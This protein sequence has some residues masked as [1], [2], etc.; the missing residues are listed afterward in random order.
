MTDIVRYDLHD[1]IAVLRFDDGKANALSPTAIAALGEAARRAGAEA[2][3]TVLLGREGRFSAGFDLT[4]M[5]KGPAEARA[6]VT[7]GADLLLG[8]ALHPR[9]LVVACTGHALAA[10]AIFLLV[11]D[12]RIGANGPFKLGF[13]EVA[14]GL[15][16]P[17]FLVELARDR[18]SKRWFTRAVSQAEI[19]DPEGAKKAG[20]LDEVVP[21]GELEARATSEA[22]RLAPLP[23]PTFAAS[24]ERE[25]GALAQR[26]RAGLEADMVRFGMP[27]P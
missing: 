3:A 27:A 1:G 14:I 15:T 22:R 13:N 4:E 20:L 6:L 5:R 24:K 2:R 26:I 25:R 23:S 18:L 12:L 17:E 19:F 9:P 8:L 10:G 16:P 21:S 11:A 7:A